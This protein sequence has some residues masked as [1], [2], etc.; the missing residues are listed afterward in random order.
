LREIEQMVDQLNRLPSN[1]AQME[2]T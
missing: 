1:Q 2:L